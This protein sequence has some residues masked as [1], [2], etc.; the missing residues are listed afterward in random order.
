MGQARF[1]VRVYYED[2]DCTGFAHHVALLR[3]L[4]RA[5]SEVFAAAGLTQGAWAERGLMFPAYSVNAVFRGPARLGDD[6]AVLTEVRRA[7]PFRL[8]FEQ[9][10]ERACDGAP[11]LEAAVDVVCTDLEARLRPLPDDAFP[12][13]P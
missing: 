3:F 2:T 1:A 6:L 9:R 5:R 7:S 13:R 8:T 4:A 10:V 11:V 12:A